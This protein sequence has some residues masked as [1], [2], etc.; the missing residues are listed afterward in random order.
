MYTGL[1]ILFGTVIGYLAAHYT[2]MPLPY[3]LAPLISVAFMSIKVP[4]VFPVGYKFPMRFRLIFIAIIGLMIGAR[5]TPELVWSLPH[6]RPS[7]VAIILFVML[8]LYGNKAVFQR[9]GGYD[10]KTAFFAAAPGGLMEAIA[11]GEAS[12]CN[13]QLLM[14]QQFLR[15]ILTITLVPIGISIWLGAPVGS[16]SG[17]SLSLA[18]H[19][20]DFNDFAIAFAVGALGLFLGLRLKIPAGQLMGPMAVAAIL[21]VAGVATIDLPP[22]VIN[23]AQVVIGASLGSRFKGMAKAAIT[24]AIVLSLV[25][26][27]YMLTLAAIITFILMQV[28]DMSALVL[29][30]SFAPGGVSE[31]SLIALSLAANPALVSLHHLVRILLTVVSMT[32]LA[33]RQSDS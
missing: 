31:M 5:V 15:I 26:V 19:V 13:I 29:F 12:G 23:F 32:V 20:P 17:V 16:A 33:P 10:D 22:W 9:L 8:S 6:Y 3:M 21:T 1:L 30:I 7:V 24:K 25:S 2:F 27:I 14:L 4:Q 11:M 28:T 18:A